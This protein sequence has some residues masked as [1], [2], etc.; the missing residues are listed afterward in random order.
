MTDIADLGVGELLRP[1]GSGG[2]RRCQARRTRPVASG[3]YRDW[4]ARGAHFLTVLPDRDAEIRFCMPDPPG[5]LIEVGQAT[6][7]V[8]G[9]L[10]EEAPAGREAEGT[11]GR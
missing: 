4:L 5:F 7:V 8:G 1:I 2:C 3:R 9:R 11:D 10:A 6:G